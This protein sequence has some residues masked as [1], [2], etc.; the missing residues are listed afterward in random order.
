MLERIHYLA[1]KR[2]DF[3]FETTLASRT[4]APWIAELLK[5]GYAWVDITCLRRL[6]AGDI[7]PALVI[8]SDYIA[9]WQ[10]HGFFM[11]IPGLSR[12]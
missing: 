5:T 6:F 8:F 1:K 2:V 3:A 10:T 9:L 12:V 11:T 4:F 7:M